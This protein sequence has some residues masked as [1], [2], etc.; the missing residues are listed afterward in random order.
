M[1]DTFIKYQVGNVGDQVGNVSDQVGN[2]VIPVENLVNQVENIS[3]QESSMLKKASDEI[4][5]LEIPLKVISKSNYRHKGSSTWQRFKGFEEELIMLVRASLPKEWKGSSNEKYY[6]ITIIANS[7]IDAGNFSKSI[8]DA[9]EGLLYDDDCDVKVVVSVNSN[10]QINPQQDK[11]KL[12]LIIYREQKEEF[13]G[14]IAL[15]K[16]NEATLANDYF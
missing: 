15:V 1:K 3:K 4:I 12:L 9:L 5:V 10:Y 16:L 13:E 2:V 11:D 6:G 14:K 7:K 8:L